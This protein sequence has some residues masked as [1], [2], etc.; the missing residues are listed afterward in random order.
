[1]NNIIPS[2]AVRAWIYGVLIA[3][4][5][6]AVFYGLATEHEVVLWLG[7]AAAALGNGLAVANT[8]TKGDVTPPPR[9]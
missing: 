7:V 8:P 5:P 3:A 4:G 6:L 2:P 1:M 9:V